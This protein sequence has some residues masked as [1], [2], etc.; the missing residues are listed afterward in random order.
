MRSALLFA[1]LAAGVCGNVLDPRAYTTEWT[2]V[3]VTETV[4]KTLPAVTTTATPTPTHTEAPVNDTNQV[5]QA[6]TQS[7]PAPENTDSSVSELAKKSTVAPAP[8]PTDVKENQ[9]GATTA[10]TSYYSTSWTEAATPAPEPTS[11]MTTTTSS[12]APTATNSY[13]HNVLYSHNVHRSNHSANSLE[14][15]DSLAHSAHDLAKD[16]VYQHNTKL[17]GGGYGQNIGYGK[18]EK[19]VGQMISNLMYNDEMGY[20]EDLY[21]QDDPD[22]AL[23]DKWGHFSQIVW[24]GTTHVGCSTVTCQ[25]LGNVDS[26]EALPFTVCNYSPA[27]NMQKEYANNVNRPLKKPV[28]TA[29]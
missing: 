11:S 20:F 8:K 10:W 3:T 29:P 28:Y 2:V 25:S 5:A 9:D 21:G 19:D 22:M 23:F 14:W 4:T 15:S 16:C 7:Q 12:A 26:S 17:D 27:G 13:Q 1:A 18:S 24:K 6:D